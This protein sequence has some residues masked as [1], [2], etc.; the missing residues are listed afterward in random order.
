MAVTGVFSTLTFAVLIGL[1]AI[2]NGNPTAAGVGIASVVAAMV[3]IVVLATAKRSASARRRLERSAVRVLIFTKR[4]VSRP[5][6]E[7][8]D[9]VARAIQEL[10]TYRLR[11]ANAVAVVWLASMNWILDA[12]CLWAVLQAFAVPLPL[13]SLPFVYAAAIVAA[14]FGFTPAGVGTVEAA[15]AVALTNLGTDASRALLAALVYRGI[16]T[17]LVLLIGWTVLVR[18]RRGGGVN[19]LGSSVTSDSAS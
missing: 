12:L 11:R 6:G 19:P 9:I 10:L 15:I 13:R 17:W 2:A 7:P 14:S 3:P 1:A 4:A 18:L 16:S 5:R 8:A